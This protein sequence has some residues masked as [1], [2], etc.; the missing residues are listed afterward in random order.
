VI[1]GERYPSADD[2]VRACIVEL[3][4]T[5]RLSPTQRRV[6]QHMLDSA[7]D[8]AFASAAEIAEAAGVSQ[9]TVTRLAGA[10]GF[11]GYPEFRTAVR[12]HMMTSATTSLGVPM[13][14]GASGTARSGVAAA[15]DS[16]R[17]N[18]VTLEG[19][20]AGDRMASAVRLIGETAALGVVGLRASAALAQYFGYFAQ[21]VLPDVRVLSDASTVR[22]GILQVHQN[23]GSVILVF[24]MPRYPAAT[25]AALA[26]ARRLGLVTVVVVDTPLVPFADLV[27]VLLVAPVGREL[28]F[29][30][31]AAAIAL[32]IALVDGVAALDPRRTQRRLEA[33]ESLVGEWAVDGV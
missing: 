17:L 10:L 28:V 16:E 19:E 20:V 33:Y 27:D 7:P 22:D 18:L 2:R 24:A 30:S 12:D 1:E 5:H 14:G 8:V 32:A 25:V 26:C 15:L 4:H 29:D 11:A 3:V 13:L 6:I 21:R 9:P 31:H 23:G